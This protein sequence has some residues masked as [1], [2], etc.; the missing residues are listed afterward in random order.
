MEA[1]TGRTIQIEKDLNLAAL[2][3][4]WI[5]AG[6][7][8]RDILCVFIG[9]GI[10]SGLILE[11]RLFRGALGAAGEIG[12]LT[13]E[14]DGPQCGCGNRGCLEQFAS[15]PAILRMMKRKM[16]DTG[17]GEGGKGDRSAG[18]E[19]TTSRIFELAQNG[20][21][22]ALQVVDEAC[23]Y[24]G[25]GLANALTL[26]NPALLILGGGVGKRFD[27]ILG[28]IWVEIRARCRPSIAG[29][30]KIVPSALWND[31]ALLGGARAFFE[32]RQGGSS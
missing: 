13:I 18:S 24:L 17:A 30:L 8:T 23:M 19:M 32:G 22:L 14:K 26:L 28:R 6:R 11:D 12:H 4:H 3:E 31:A 7:G 2:G 25:I 27:F 16:A 20:D 29:S 10:G 9:T 5:G 21:G 1:R 15:G